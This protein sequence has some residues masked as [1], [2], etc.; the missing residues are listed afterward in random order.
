[1]MQN[2]AKLSQLKVNSLGCFFSTE[3]FFIGLFNCAMYSINRDC[4]LET[5]FYSVSLKLRSY[6]QCNHSD[7]LGLYF[8]IRT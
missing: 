7:L 1:M 3:L 6:L 2:R 5:V 8:L 4:F